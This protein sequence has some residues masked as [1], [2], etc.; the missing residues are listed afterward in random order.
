MM[1][2]KGRINRKFIEFKKIMKFYKKNI[3]NIDQLV[4][5]LLNN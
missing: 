2:R 4:N 1:N 5:L 3:V